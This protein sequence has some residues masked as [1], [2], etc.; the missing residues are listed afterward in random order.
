MTDCCPA[1]FVF[2]E[3]NFTSSLAHEQMEI[4]QTVGTAFL[5]GEDVNGRKN[6]ISTVVYNANFMVFLK[7]VPFLTM[8]GIRTPD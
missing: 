8:L 2:S 6:G 1:Y 7:S 4:Y 5:T 3:F